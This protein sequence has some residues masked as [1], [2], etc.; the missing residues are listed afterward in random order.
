MVNTLPTTAVIRYDAIVL[1]LASKVLVSNY[2]VIPTPPVSKD[3]YVGVLL[4]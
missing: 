3:S 2:V 4:Y 1:K